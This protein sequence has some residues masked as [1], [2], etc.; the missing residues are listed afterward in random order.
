[1]GWD[2]L[3]CRAYTQ[4]RRQPTMRAVLRRRL[5]NECV[6]A[7]LA[8]RYCMTRLPGLSWQ[9]DTP[10]NGWTA[11][12]ITPGA[13]AVI[14][15]SVASYAGGAPLTAGS[16]CTD[17]LFEVTPIA[18][19]WHFALLVMS[20]YWRHLRRFCPLENLRVRGFQLSLPDGCALQVDGDDAT[21]VLANHSTLSIRVAGQIPV[22]HALASVDLPVRRIVPAPTGRGN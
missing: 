18:R 16:S 4:L 12:V 8:L 11:G 7:V 1:V 2:A 14:V 21:G 3:V 10:G 17:G 20:R 19:P 6:Y 22:V 5:I 9:L 15:S 13:C